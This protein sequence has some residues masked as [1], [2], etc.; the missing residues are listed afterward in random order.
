[1]AIIEKNS[2]LNK[3][4]IDQEI[5]DLKREKAELEKQ[6]EKKR[7]QDEVNNLKKKLYED[8]SSKYTYA[9][10]EDLS[11]LLQSRRKSSSFFED[12]PKTPAEFAWHYRPWS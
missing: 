4:N 2:H 7:L 5:A 11:K 12:M 3:K 9:T 10:L 6:L 8:N 1:M